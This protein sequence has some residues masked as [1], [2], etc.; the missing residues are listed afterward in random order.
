[1]SRPGATRA[2]RRGAR[3][4]RPLP[5]DGPHKAGARAHDSS[6]AKEAGHARKSAGLIEGKRFAAS[7]TIELRLDLG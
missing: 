3:R 5:A 6:A 4:P 1:M 7:G 2:R